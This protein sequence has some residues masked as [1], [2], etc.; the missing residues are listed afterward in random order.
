M[1]AP[2]IKIRYSKVKF[3]WNKTEQDDFK[4]IN[5]IVALNNLLAYQYFN[6]EFK[7]HT[8]AR[9]FQLGAFISQNGKPIYFYSRKL[10]DAQK[11]YAVK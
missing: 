10:T 6:E 4:E 3:K 1:L 9:E 5:Q 2:L 8:N 7:I 11:S